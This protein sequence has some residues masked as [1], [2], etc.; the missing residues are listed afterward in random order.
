MGSHHVGAGL[1]GRRIAA[2]RPVQPP[3]TPEFDYKPVIQLCGFCPRPLVTV[4]ACFLE[5]SLC[6]ALPCS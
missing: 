5:P 2:M 3:Q 4:L 6:T 1:S